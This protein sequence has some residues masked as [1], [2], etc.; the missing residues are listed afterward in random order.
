[1]S[2]TIKFKS[3]LDKS[4]LLCYYVPVVMHNTNSNERTAGLMT[5]TVLFKDN[6]K[7]LPVYEICMDGQR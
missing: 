6:N 1:M 3:V 7:Y 5:A 2:F 4:Q